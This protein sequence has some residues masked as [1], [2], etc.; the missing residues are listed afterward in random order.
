MHEVGLLVRASRNAV[1][2]PSS[3]PAAPAAASTS[4]QTAQPTTQAQPP[5]PQADQPPE[6]GPSMVR[7]AST[8]LPA[9]SAYAD[10]TMADGHQ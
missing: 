7:F 4:T 1:A 9:T 2:G 10:I 5:A 6:P 3:Q 8:P